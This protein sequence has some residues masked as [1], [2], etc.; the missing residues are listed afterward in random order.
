M[1]ASY[2]LGRWGKSTLFIGLA[3]LVLSGC[4]IGE[5]SN[6]PQSVAELKPH[7]GSGNGGNGDE[8]NDDTNDLQDYPPTLLFEHAG[9]EFCCGGYD[10]YGLHDFE[11]TDDFRSLDGGEWAE[12]IGG[13]VGERV[14][15]SFGN[16]YPNPDAES[17]EWI[18]WEATGT[19]TTPVFEI[20]ASYI[21]FL[22]GGGTNPY[23]HERATAVA[24]Y[25]NG[26]LVRDA[27]GN[28]REDSLSPVT[29]NVADYIGEDAYIVIV[30]KHN[31]DGSDDA[32]PFILVDHIEASSDPE[33]APSGAGGEAELIFT[34]EPAT[35][36]DPLFSL[37]SSDAH[38]AGFEFCCGGFNTY[39]DHGFGV[40]GDMI[41]LDG[42]EWAADFDGA[43]GDRIFMSYGRHHDGDFIAPDSDFTGRLQSPEFSISANFINFLLAGGS[44]RFD[45]HNATAVVLRVNGEVVRQ[46]SGNDSDD[47][48]W[49]T[50]DV[51]SFIGQRGVVE[52]ID[53]HSGEEDGLLPYV[54]ADEFRISDK[55]A[56]EPASDS[57]VTDNPA[58]MSASRLKMGDPNPYYENGK[59]Y[60]FYL[61]DSGRHPWYLAETSDLLTYSDPVE[62]LPVGSDPDDQDNWTG[63]GSVVEH[64][65]T[66]YMFYTG[67]NQNITPVEAVM[68]ATSA[69][70]DLE[71][72]T[73]QPDLTFTGSDGYSDYDF[74]DPWVF[75]NEFEQ[76]YWLLITTRYESKAA[77]GLY[78]SD[79]LQVWDARS[80]L[81]VEE[82]PLNL[83][84]PEMLTLDG[85]DYLLYSDQRDESRQVRHLV[86]NHND[87]WEYPEYDALDGRAFYAAR[88][89]GPENEKILFG[90]VPHK[91]G[92]SNTGDHRWGGDIVTHQI[93]TSLDGGLSVSL[94]NSLAEQIDNPLDWQPTWESG[95]VSVEGTSISLSDNSA[96]VGDRI[97]GIRRLT[98]TLTG[99][100]EGAPFGIQFRNEDTG[101]ESFIEFDVLNESVG[102]FF[103]GD[104]ENPESP[105]VSSPLSGEDSVQVELWLNPELDYGVIYINDHRA[106]TFRFYEM[107]SYGFGFY[108]TDG[109][110]VKSLE[111]FE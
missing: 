99:Y 10:T 4:K 7:D 70:G 98:A 78:T 51:S 15:A 95:D 49:I 8:D 63:S 17:T 93:I 3:C 19:L 35:E 60:L 61:H 41:H 66:Y 85:E 80:P 65:G 71:S 44:N 20:P 46:A 59:F 56:A 84:V 100:T 38:I 29:W 82:S 28:G 32:L 62:V 22:I 76:T 6:P 64:D 21:N 94:P 101:V 83:E 75:W 53:E 27:T 97:S 34:D 102:F 86:D 31:D 88:T 104:Q 39:G 73:K 40:T 16:G 13:S 55:A 81:Y 25:V 90:W 92:L 77:I 30:D 23:G 109:L 9:F 89:A 26:E 67:H 111:V 48:E 110:E 37:Q 24:L 87:G 69:D 96:L 91:Y 45:G 42:G 107:D 12:N 11:A 68:V 5:E 1:T 47:L 79:D 103:T 54:L 50:W 58:S 108:A 36:G 52:I 43:V 57:R 105:S 14:F 72:W 33:T 18:G 2:V 74:R 106:L